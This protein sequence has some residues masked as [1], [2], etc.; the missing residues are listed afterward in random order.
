M[1]KMQSDQCRHPSPQGKRD[2]SY[3]SYT[4]FLDS[5][6]STRFFIASNS[7][8]FCAVFNLALKALSV[9]HQ[10]SPISFAFS[11]EQITRRIWMVRSSMSTSLILISPAMTS[12]LSRTR[13]NTSA[14]VA[15]LVDCVIAVRCLSIHICLSVVK[16]ESPLLGGD[17]EVGKLVLV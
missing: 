16:L 9:A 10:S 5:S 7:S 14:S 6:I 8:V 1:H 4:S 2:F 13:S 12:P 11:T 17:L 15:E 3:Y